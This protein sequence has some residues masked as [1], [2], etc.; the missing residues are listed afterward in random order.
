MPK[1]SRG[2]GRP[3]SGKEK[4]TEAPSIR[5]DDV[6]EAEDSDP[7]ELRHADRFDQVENY[8]YE[9][10]SDFED[11]EIDEEMA[12]TE[13][14]KKMFG[15]MFDDMDAP[16]SGDEGGSGGS[17]AEDLL[18]SG[19]SEKEAGDEEE[20]GWSDDDEEEE[21]RG[22]GSRGQ[23]DEMDELFG[24]SPSGS[25]QEEDGQD[26]SASG[27]DAG[28]GEEDEEGDEAAAARHAAMLEAVTGGGA[29]AARRKRRVKEVV[30]TEAYPE[31]A[32]NLAPS[33][34][35][36]EL[37]MADLIQGL[38]DSKGKLGAARKALERLERRTAPV[39]APLPG[40]IKQRQERKAGYEESKREADKWLPIVKANREAPTLRFTADKAAVPR[41]TTTA[42]IA[43]KH[44]PENDMENEVA[45]LLQAAGAH[46]AKAVAEAEEALSMKALTVKEARER[47]NRLAKMRALLFYHEAKAKRMK[48]IK[49]KEYRRKLKK[50]DQR[51][52]EAAGEGGEDEIRLEQEQA[53]FDR[54]KERLTLKHRNTSRW[55]R[56]AIKRGQTLTDEGTRLAVAE[57]LRLGQ[58]LR[59]RVDRMKR[60]KGDDSDASTSASDGEDGSGSEEEEGGNTFAGPAAGRGMGSKAKVAAL[61]LLQGGA[62]A[63]DEAP[64]TGL[65]ALPFM[66]RALD[67]KK[68]EAQQAA[69]E[70]LRELEGEGG[71]EDAAAAAANGGGGAVG[72][73]AFAGTGVDQRKQWE[74]VARKEAAARDGDSDPGSDVEET[75]EAKA[76]RL[77][78]RLG[79]QLDDEEEE[80]EQQRQRAADAS[81]VAV[82]TAD[83]AAAAGAA[84]GE[85]GGAVAMS[86]GPIGVSMPA[87]G[88]KRRSNGGSVLE[89]V[90][91][92]Q[93][94]GAAQ[95]DWLFSS[96]QGE[97]P[98]AAAGNGAA[99][100]GKRSRKQRQSGAGVSIGPAPASAGE[101]Q[102]NGGA[103]PAAD[104]QQQQQQQQQEGGEAPQPAFL[105]S[106]SFQGGRPGYVFKKGPQG[107]GYYL[108]G[109][110]AV[111]A[112][113]AAK[114]LVRRQKQQQQRGQ[115]QKQ[116]P[117]AAAGSDSEEE[118][119]MKPVQ[120]KQNGGAGLSQAELIG[121]AF[122]GDDVAAEF[123]ASKAAEVEG[124]LPK[125][126]VPGV[127]PGW[128][129]WA[130]NQ[131]EPQWAIDAKKKAAQRKAAAAAGRKDAQLQYVVISEKWDKK[132]SKYKTP[133]VPFPYDSKETYERAMRQPLGRE[134]NTDASFRNLT[135]P[136]LLKDAGVIIEPI[137]F[138]KAMAHHDEQA[139]KKR[140]PVT[141][142]AGGMPKRS[143]QRR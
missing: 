23:R 82:S 50:S 13:E 65:F 10:P 119:H 107:V 109:S 84:A 120:Q 90:A 56:R 102:Q 83:A 9:M 29:A 25:S 22:A 36:G 114:Q 129:I 121:R 132:S 106:K 46:S 38:G 57:Q 2:G 30:V 139:A 112:A 64:A 70:V 11:E 122:A 12:F 80:E 113:R 61:E 47:Q 7:D 5:P 117:A 52:A 85:V 40:P 91:A 99:A 98:Q 6:Y 86:D 67:R 75:T 88:G 97:T 77:G 35:D 33:A 134:Y 43:A 81:T 53:E 55:A 14:D 93:R 37:T 59:Q 34:N 78:K 79:W 135:R 3:P 49:S 19:E 72:R 4:K 108:D 68:L 105:R 101:R 15:H 24:D 133:A 28:S 92:Q 48:K 42:A 110:E 71:V 123:A 141:T 17:E 115:Q 18:S 44:Q 103:P 100:G 58:E 95:Q 125:E 20:E 62:G 73:L 136:A 66:R 143:K 26:G 76:R 104:Q 16:A 74:R 94:G 63:D 142:I 131:R 32:Y 1:P 21:G 60:P 54:A 27:D 137:R 89:Q 39:A 69:Q 126:E 45:A 31:S 111:K 41:T 118:R 51:K 130:G 116:Q 87:P 127:L 96:R 138:S 140:A 128:G 124:E 8:E